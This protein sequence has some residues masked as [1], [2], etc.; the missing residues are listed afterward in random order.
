LLEANA[1]RSPTAYLNNPIEERNKYKWN[2]D[3]EMTLLRFENSKGV[4][5]S[6]LN[7]FA[8]H[9]TSMNNTNLL[10]SGDNKGY[11]AYTFEKAINGRDI[12]PGYGPFI[13]G[14]AQSNEGDN[15]P[16]TLGAFCDNGHP[17]E[18]AHSTCDGTSQGCHGYGPGKT[19]F[20]STQIIGHKQFSKAMEL[21]LSA[22][23]QLTGV[24]DVIHHYIDMSN[25]SVSAKYSTTGRNET[26][27]VGTSA[28]HLQQE[29]LMVQEI[30]ISFKEPILL[31][32]I[33]I[34][35]SLHIFFPNQLHNK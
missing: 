11:A 18:Q 13:A 27:C 30:S 4:P 21:F 22:K 15:T 34:G 24:I 20:E 32:Q 9:G 28:M 3:K 2:V 8:V 19:D 1:N 10:I 33:H 14:F 5:T 16:N 29:Q 7:W 26:T 17:C 12:M 6:M 35:I 25:V 31:Q 23:T